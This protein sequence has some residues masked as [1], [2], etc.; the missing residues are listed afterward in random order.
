MSVAVCPDCHRELDD[1]E[2]DELTG[3]PTSPPPAGEATVQDE[4]AGEDGEE[5][6]RC[7]TCGREV[8]DVRP[9]APWHFKVLLVG[10]VIYLCWRLYQGIGWLVHHA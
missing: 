8:D 10:S 3:G 9:K 1:G 2:P 5:A 4:D 7:P 6:E